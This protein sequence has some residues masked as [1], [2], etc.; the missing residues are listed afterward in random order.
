MLTAYFGLGLPAAPVFAPQSGESS[1]QQRLSHAAPPP[2][3]PTESN[4]PAGVRA[5]PPPAAGVMDSA[6]LEEEQEYLLLDLEQS[7][8]LDHDS[9]SPPRCESCSTG[10]EFQTFFPKLPLCSSAQLSTLYWGMKGAA[11]RADGICSLTFLL[12][13]CESELKNILDQNQTSSSSGQSAT[14]QFQSAWRGSVRFWS[15]SVKRH[16]CLFWF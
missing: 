1:P 12:C 9:S 14:L 11:P 15:S 5:A 3:P 6:M 16:W 8:R 4:V 10:N 2:P 7:F 13:I